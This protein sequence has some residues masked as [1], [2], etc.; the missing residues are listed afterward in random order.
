MRWIIGI[1]V[2]FIY[3]LIPLPIQAIILVADVMLTGWGVDE[4]LLIIAI[5]VRRF[6]KG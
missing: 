3:C 6:A 4:I 1:G 2:F 5:I